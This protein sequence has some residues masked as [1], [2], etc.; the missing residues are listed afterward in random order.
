MPWLPVVGLVEWTAIGVGRFPVVDRQ[1]PRYSN[2]CVWGEE[3]G[4]YVVFCTDVVAFASMMTS[5]VTF[6]TST[7]R[8]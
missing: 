5:L 6:E 7:Y 4:F 3:V 1:P 8:M 2:V